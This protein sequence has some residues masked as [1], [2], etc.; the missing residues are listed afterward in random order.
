MNPPITTWQRLALKALIILAIALLGFALFVLWKARLHEARAVASHPPEGQFVTVDGHRVHVVVRGDGP[1]LVLIHGSSGNTRDFTFALMDRL[2]TRYRVFVVDRP[3]LGYTERINRTG[4]TITQQADI[5]SRAVAE[6]GAAQPIVLGHSYGGAVALAWAVNFPDRLS[7][8]VPLAA[9]SNI[10]ETGLSRYYWATSHPV[11]GPLVIPV[12]TA[13]VS[14]DYVEQAISAIFAP[15]S[16]PEGYGAFVGA[17]LTLRRDSL[18]ANALQRK[19]LLG[20]IT[21]LYPRYGQIS[22]PTEIVHGDDDATVP[23]WNH[24]DRLATQIPGA[25][26]TSMPGVGHMPHHVDPDG[27]IAAIDRVAA[28]AG[29]R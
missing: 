27:V 23:H 22:V 10:W 1:D 15:Q 19:N 21:A 17:G 25:V 4:A 13:F 29:L 14:D 3:G 9:A 26:Y 24:A 2:A 12:L 8:L 20:E 16:A 28:R 6:L 5:L 18:R 11:I 7:G